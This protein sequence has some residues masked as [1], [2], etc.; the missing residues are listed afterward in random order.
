METIF[1]TWTP[2]TLSKHF[3]AAPTA[4]SSWITRIPPSRVFGF[5]MISISRLLFWIFINHKSFN[6]FVTKFVYLKYPTWR[7]IA[8][9][10]IHKLLV[11][12]T[13]NFLTDLKS[14]SWS[15]GTWATSRRRS[16]PSYWISVPPLTSA[17]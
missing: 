17:L 11:L 2:Q 15:F 6:W 7:L 9:K 5:T 1:H 14:S 13:L 10:S 3:I 4:V 8:S 16:L 12:N